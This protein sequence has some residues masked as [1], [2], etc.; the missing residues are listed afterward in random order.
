MKKS[1][2]WALREIGKRDFDYQEKA[3]L[4][5]HELIENGDK[6]Q[7]W[8]GKDALKEIGKAGQSGGAAAV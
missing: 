8:I 2:S 7:K 5:A 4:L 6:A 1:V 3:V